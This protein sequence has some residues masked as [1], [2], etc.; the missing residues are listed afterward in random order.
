MKR[1]RSKLTKTAV[2]LIMIGALMSIMDVYFHTFLVARFYELASNSTEVIAKYYIRVYIMIAFSFVIFGNFSKKHSKATLRTGIVLNAVVLILIMSLE[3]RVIE[4]YQVLAII[5]GLAQGC[6]YSPISNLIGINTSNEEGSVIKEYCTG[7]SITVSIVSIVFP[8]TIGAYLN[9]ASFT[10]MTGFVLILIAVQIM[11]TFFIKD[12]KEEPKK[13]N[14]KAFIK[15]VRETREGKAVKNFYKISFCNGIVTSVL[16]RI[17]TIL[18]LMLYET[19]FNLGVLSTIFAFSSVIITWS[20]RRFYKPE[21]MKKAVIVAAIVPSIV[22][23]IF[24]MNVT[25]GTFIVYKLVSA[26]FICILTTLSGY[27]RY[28]SLDKRVFSGFDAEHQSLTEMFLA[29]GRVSGFCALLMCSRVFVG[30]LALQIFLVVIGAVI[31]AYSRYVYK[32]I[33]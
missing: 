2:A 7:S 14:L 3:E 32:T 15:K 8:V 26:V 33:K 27:A 12:A 4:Y 22:V 18:I 11:I 20:V 28:E 17:V 5:F 9:V 10:K 13:Y 25:R 30:I 21:R 23:I 6:Y 16:D 31:V 29:A 24:A 19:S 1:K